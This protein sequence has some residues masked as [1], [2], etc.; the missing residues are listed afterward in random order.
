M[1]AS[2]SRMG[3]IPDDAWRTRC[4]ALKNEL[5]AVSHRAEQEL[6]VWSKSM[7]S[8]YRRLATHEVMLCTLASG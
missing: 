7:Q 5:L 6:Q 8:A 2:S 1:E 4:Q 3:A